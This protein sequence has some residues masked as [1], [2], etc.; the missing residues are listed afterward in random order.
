MATDNQHDGDS[1]LADLNH[2]HVELPLTMSD[3]HKIHDKFTAYSRGMCQPEIAEFSKCSSTRTWS[4]MWACRDQRNKMMECVRAHGTDEARL[5]IRREYIEER[6]AK[7]AKYLEEKGVAGEE[8][9]SS[10][11]PMG[12]KQI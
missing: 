9:K 5:R 3:E 4:V 11:N 2:R 1:A 6:E 7:Y 12:Q 8:S 10:W